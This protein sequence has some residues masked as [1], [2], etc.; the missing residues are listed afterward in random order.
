MP[1][2]PTVYLPAVRG[3]YSLPDGRMMA[4]PFNSSTAIMFYNKDAFKKAGLDP[5]KP[6]Q[7]WPE[8]I[9]A[10]RKIKATN[11]AACGFTTAWPTWTQFE[12][13][14]AIHDVPLATKAN[15]MAGLGRRAQDQQPTARQACAGAHGHAQGRELQVR[16]T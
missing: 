4:M 7:T 2:D 14:S 6:P 16:R 10:A 5:T 12:Q 9:E 3:Y 15:G 11:A 13:F 1:F 8:L